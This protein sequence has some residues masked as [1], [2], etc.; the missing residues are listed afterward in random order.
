[1]TNSSGS[2][3]TSEEQTVLQTHPHWVTLVPPLLLGIVFCAGGLVLLARP[4]S[5]VYGA[6]PIDIGWAGIIAII[7]GIL[8]IGFGVLHR[9]STELAVTTQRITVSAG[10]VARRTLDILLPEVESIEVDQGMMGQLLDFGSI[11]VRG[12]GGT[13]ER[14]AMI[15]HP[16]KFRREVQSQSGAEHSRR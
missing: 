3:Q 9:E 11:V 15:A 14:L 13:P 4:V 16:F 8:V 10:V 6:P 7:V 12:T 5:R 2:K 1:M